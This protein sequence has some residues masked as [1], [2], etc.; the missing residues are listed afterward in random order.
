VTPFADIEARAKARHASQS[1]DDEKGL[2]ALLSKPLS[3]AEIV[4]VPDERWLSQ[5]TR[6]IFEA[7]FNW[8]LIDKRW[9]QFEAAFEGFDITRWVF[10]SDD[11]VDDLLK[12]PGLVAHAQKSVRSARMHVSFRI[13]A[14]RMAQRA[15]GSPHGRRNAI[16]SCAWS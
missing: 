6:C 11:D 15:R 7:G 4:A 9:P 16:S 13:W 10:M 3:Q 14:R 1:P 8:D 2:D 5:M 12:A